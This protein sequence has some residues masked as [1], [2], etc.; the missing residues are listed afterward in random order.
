MS[1]R[2][3]REFIQAQIV[4]TDRL[5]ELASRMD[6]KGGHVSA[7]VLVRCFPPRPGPLPRGEGGPPVILWTSRRSG[8]V[9]AFVQVSVS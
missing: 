6:Y 5:I 2:E 4:K 3:K 9:G 1:L 8:F 7:R